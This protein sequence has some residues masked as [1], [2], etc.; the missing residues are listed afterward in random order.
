M[1]RFSYKKGSALILVLVMAMVMMGIIG[2]LLMKSA[3][4]ARYVRQQKAL[5]VS[6]HIAQSGLQAAT[7]AIRKYFKFNQT[8]MEVHG[9]C[10]DWN[11]IIVRVNH[12]GSNKWI[13]L[14]TG[15]DVP[16]NFANASREVYDQVIENTPIRLRDNNNFRVQLT[17]L[18]SMQNRNSNESD[19]NVVSTGVFDG[20]AMAFAALILQVRV[21]GS[22]SIP[23][24]AADEFLEITGSGQIASFP[25]PNEAL[26]V[27]NEDIRLSVP[28]HGELHPGTNGNL[29]GS[30]NV[31]PPQD[32]TVEEATSRLKKRFELPPVKIVF[33]Q[34]LPTEGNF[35]KGVHS[36]SGVHHFTD[37]DIKGTINISG[38]TEIYVQNNFHI[39]AGG[40]IVIPEGAKLTLFI[41]GTATFN[42]HSVANQTANP[43]NLQVKIAHTS[44]NPNQDDVI[45]NGTSDFHGIM[46]APRANIKILGTNQYFGNIVGNRIRITGNAVFNDFT[47][48]QPHQQGDEYLFVLYTNGVH[49]TAV[50]D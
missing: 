7:V 27:S 2:T 1:R 18:P 39:N 47:S 15:V 23:R 24:N 6:Y 45:I 36:L 50:E 29:A 42:G 21:L 32:I 3:S 10:N 43:Q 14:T 26:F 13:E 20:E 4:H 49:R 19:F 9:N 22:S 28:F 17:A 25:E 12:K 48:G 31:V 35:K 38:N 30:E 16:A 8:P 40:Q 37:L 44:L 41:A 5:K 11:S 33:P 46:Y 34:A